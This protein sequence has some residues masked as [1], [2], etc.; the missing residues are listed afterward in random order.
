M[1][2]ADEERGI[3]SYMKGYPCGQYAAICEDAT[4][5]RLLVR[6]ENADL[7]YFDLGYLEGYHAAQ[8]GRRTA[9]TWQ[10]LMPPRW[11]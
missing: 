3:R 2:N 7:T 1:T 6:K 10:A 5:V 11:P 4:Q 8:Q 9:I